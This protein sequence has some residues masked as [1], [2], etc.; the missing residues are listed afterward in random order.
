[1]VKLL[2][3]N[4]LLVARGMT[5]EPPVIWAGFDVEVLLQIPHGSLHGAKWHAT[6][7]LRAVAAMSLWRR[8]FGV[9]RLS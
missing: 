1:M 4:P 9:A 7:I 5:V 2:R 6:L 8:L 3:I